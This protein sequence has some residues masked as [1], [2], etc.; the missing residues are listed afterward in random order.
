MAADK[1]IANLDPFN[2]NISEI[3]SSSSIS[4]YANDMFLVSHPLTWTN[5][6]WSDYTTYRVALSDL[7]RLAVNQVY[8]PL[9][10]QI[11]TDLSLGDLAHQ[12][13][14]LRSDQA[15]RNII[16]L[17]DN[18]DSSTY[19]PLALPTSKLSSIQGNQALCSNLGFK[20][21]AFKDEVQLELSALAHKSYIT[22]ADV[23]DGAK[24]PSAQID[25]PFRDLCLSDES[26]LKLSALA[27]QDTVFPSQVENGLSIQQLLS[28]GNG[29]W[30]P[31]L[32][33]LYLSSPTSTTRGSIA[34]GYVQ[35]S[36]STNRS[37][38]V[39]VDISGNAYVNVPW[40]Y[41]SDA[42]SCRISPS[43]SSNT[44][45]FSQTFTHYENGVRTSSTTLT[46]AVVITPEISNNITRSGASGNRGRIA[47]FSDDNN[48]SGGALLAGNH[49][50]VYR[51]DGT[52]DSLNTASRTVTGL[53]ASSAYSYLYDLTANLP[54][55]SN[56]VKGAI[57]T[58]YSSN[59]TANEANIAVKVDSSTAK[60]YVT[61]PR[62]T[63]SRLGGIK[64]GAVASAGRYP[65][66]LDDDGN[67]Y[68]K[69]GDSDSSIDLELFDMMFPVG[70]I[71]LTLNNKA[72]LQ[73]K[74]GISWTQIKGYYLFAAG[75]LADNDKY[76]AGATIS[77]GLPTHAHDFSFGF[78][79]CN[80]SSGYPQHG[81]GSR[82]D[83]GSYIFTTGCASNA[84]YGKS[85][86]VRP[87]GYAV[88][89]FRRET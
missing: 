16:K 46:D 24:F 25:V 76:S 77:A 34:V 58:G 86:T 42:T 7:G 57:K 43:M 5:D 27:H 51:E 38:A 85:T 83:H 53:M 35:S 45:V 63:S 50:K 23:M 68:A 52:F 88:N 62:A 22:S 17:D 37:Y 59:Y 18:V 74:N 89:V 29:G 8:K 6:T 15:G 13:K 3:G 30:K 26:M 2:I 48:I 71:Y 47:V 19:G 73:G 60:A 49:Q 1:T 39:K 11:S 69:V 79:A 28:V 41:A 87:K 40:R 33:Q 21:L 44:I 72:P 65:I 4:S 56:N 80:S 84:I 55:A 12:D 75:E 66:R 64:V 14:L 20:D 10:D 9:L 61:I 70:S 32:D 31:V 36:L 82:C 54:T 67:A 81:G 78:N